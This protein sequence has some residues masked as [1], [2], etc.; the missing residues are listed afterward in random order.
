MSPGALRKLRIGL[1]VLVA[2]IAV[3]AVLLARRRGPDASE[4]KELTRFGE[5]P[6]FALVDQAARPVTRDQLLGTVWVADFIFTSCTES[7]PMLTTRMKS[8]DRALFEAAP[9]KAPPRVKLVSI[10]VDPAVDTPARLSEFATKWKADPSRWWFLTGATADV[11]RV[12]TEGF[13]VG[14]DRIDRGPG[15]V[16]IVHA[17]RFVLVDRRAQIRGY[18]DTEAPDAMKLLAADA[19]RL[20]GE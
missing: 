16:D 17:N 13:K 9:G 11:T 19:V 8:L 20:A 4:A 1:W 5:V 6:P 18:Y 7:C 10:T 14:I 12:V 3:P 2:V 15:P